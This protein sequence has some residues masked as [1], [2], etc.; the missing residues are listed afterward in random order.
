MRIPRILL[1]LSALLSPAKEFAQMTYNFGGGFD[2]LSKGEIDIAFSLAY[3]RKKF[4]FL[5]GRQAI[6]VSGIYAPRF[7]TYFFVGVA[8]RKEKKAHGHISVGACISFAPGLDSIY[9]VQLRPAIKAGIFGKVRHKTYVGF[10]FIVQPF[11]SFL[12]D[13]LGK[14]DKVGTIA[15]SLML[16]LRLT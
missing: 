4:T 8:T 16:T 1:F 3:Q 9:P 2:P 7:S 15:T 13:R 10:E 14:T 5:E 6:R 12:T 11:D